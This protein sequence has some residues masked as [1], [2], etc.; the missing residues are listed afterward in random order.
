MGDSPV[1]STSHRI[2][3]L[4]RNPV[5][6]SP[7]RDVQCPRQSED[8]DSSI[9]YPLDPTTD[10]G[11]VRAVDLPRN[12]DQ[13]TGIR[14]VIGNPDDAA[15]AQDLLDGRVGQLIVGGA[16][17]QLSVDHAPGR[18]RECAAESARGACQGD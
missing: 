14:Y 3:A 11:G 2:D 6:G 1:I 9:E 13:T 16:A 12:L 7:G 10:G 8:L 18:R 15:T 17:Y 5:R 4:L